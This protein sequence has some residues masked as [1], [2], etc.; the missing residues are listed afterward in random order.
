MIGPPSVYLSNPR[1]TFDL[2]HSFKYTPKQQQKNLSNRKHLPSRNKPF[3]KN[4]IKTF[5]P[6][7][8]IFPGHRAD[9]SRFYILSL[10]FF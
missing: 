5:P 3:K 6:Y 1:L 7:F 4:K 2:N 8:S 9:K 10:S